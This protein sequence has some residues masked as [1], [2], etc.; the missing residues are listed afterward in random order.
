MTKLFEEI[1][2]APLPLKK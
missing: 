2:T 1:C